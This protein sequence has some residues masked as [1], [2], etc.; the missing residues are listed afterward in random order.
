MIPDHWC[1]PVAQAA[2]LVRVPRGTVDRWVSAGKVPVVRR[3]KQLRLVRLGDVRAVALAMA[4]SPQS[5][6]ARK[7]NHVPENE[8]TADEV[9]ALVAEQMRRLPKWWWKEARK[10]QGAYRPG[11]RVIPAAVLYGRGR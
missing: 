4:L 3:H 9:E 5:Q 2:Q 6:G 1:V 11:I 8:P 7:A 10:Q